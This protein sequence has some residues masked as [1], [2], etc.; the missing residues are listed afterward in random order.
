[1][2][3]QLQSK[4]IAKNT[5]LLYFRMILGMVVSLYTSRVVLR[6]LGVDD[7]GIYNI[8]GGV[9]VM[10][11]FINTFLTS[12]CQR[13]LSFSI[14][15][16]SIDETKKIFSTSLF[17]HIIVLLL[18]VLVAETAGLYFVC[19]DLVIPD[20]RF[21]AALYVFHIMVV[22]SCISI[23]KVPY[24]AAIIAEEKMNFYA[25]TSIIE[26]VFRLVVVYL[27][28]ILPFDKLIVYSFLHLLV[29]VIMLLWYKIYSEKKFCY[30][31]NSIRY[32]KK[33]LKSMISFSGWNLFGS[34]ADIGYKQGT[35]IVLNLFHGVVLN[36]AMGI[37]TTVRSSIYS[38]ISNIQVAANPQIIK[39]YAIGEYSYF[40]NLIYRI[41]KY[42]YYLMLFLAIPVILNIQYILQIWLGDAP[43]YS[44]S[45]IVLGLIF[46]LIDCL[47]GP[48][49]TS[50][51]ATGK[52]RNYQLLVS[53]ILLLNIPLSYIALNLGY[54]PNSILVVQIVV[55]LF[56]LIVRLLFSCRCA[57]LSITDYLKRVILP[58]CVVTLLS[59]PLPFY[60][61]TGFEDDWRKLL[62]T[63]FTSVASVIV[64]VLLVGM[65]KRERYW[66][67]QIIQNR[68]K[69]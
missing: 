61:A 19:K 34:I 1:M 64:S 65:T 49:W 51:Q 45:L 46:C 41:S 24:N 26:N 56:T 16:D 48:L 54:S 33:Y 59:V 55:S 69:K 15:K 28:I 2:A 8:I 22:E 27:L 36:A 13:Y 21:T 63:G 9:I 67:F 4:K 32:D 18:F 52:I 62:V 10:F 25:Y 44:A 5:V 35:N 68:I 6:V 66:F 42:S 17:I 3:E 23:F 29:S 30:C 37:A 7:F 31:T 57:V 11:S 53:I 47:H 60:V 39:S 58:I 38:F 20:A 43:E 14:A 12:A 40:S 50:M